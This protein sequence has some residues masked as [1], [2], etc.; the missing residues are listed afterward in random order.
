MRST[1]DRK[2]PPPRPDRSA[3]FAS[4]SPRPAVARMAAPADLVV[5]TAPV[6][7]VEHRKQQSIRDSARGEECTV[8]IVGACNSDP[9]TT[10]W[11][12]FPGLDAGR[13]M[14]MKAID[15]AGAYCCSGC[16]DAIDG[17]REAPPGASRTSMLLDWH[18][19]HL[20]S[21]VRLKQKGL[22]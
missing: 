20:R 12:H 11:S 21:L 17:R 5:S 9:S 14:G 10:V 3:E 7:K 18:A 16:H 8:R 2:R 15:E 13:G 4:W 19:G 22:I 1:L 6:L